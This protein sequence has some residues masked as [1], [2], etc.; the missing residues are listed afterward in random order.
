ML[1]V[2]TVLDIVTYVD[3]VD[4]LVR[5]FLKSGRENYNFIILCHE[6]NELDAARAHEEET[7]LAVVNIVNKRLIK[8]EH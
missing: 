7:I 2:E 6:F 5:I 1:S 4:H 8:V 3:L